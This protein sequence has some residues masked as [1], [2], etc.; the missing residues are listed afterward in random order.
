MIKLSKFKENIMKAVRFYDIG[1]YALTQPQTSEFVFKHL[2]QP[3]EPTSRKEDYKKIQTQS[4]E[5]IEK[6][7]DCYFYLAN[8]V[9]AIILSQFEIFL[10]EILRNIFQKNPDFL[11]GKPPHKGKSFEDAEEDELRYFHSRSYK[12]KIAYFK[13]NFKID[14]SKHEKLITKINRWKNNFF[15]EGKMYAFTRD[16]IAAVITVVTEI[17]NDLSDEADKAFDIKVT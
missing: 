2:L 13:Y 7:K 15:H 1:M 3:F 12:K 14:W 5:A 17:A 4:V 16:S 8:S 11:K 9:N 6:I 10:D